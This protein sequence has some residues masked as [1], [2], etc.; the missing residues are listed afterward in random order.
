MYIPLS[1]VGVVASIPVNSIVD[2]GFKLS[3]I[4]S[5]VTVILLGKPTV[6]DISPDIACAA[7]VISTSSAVPSKVTVLVASAITVFPASAVVLEVPIPSRVVSPARAVAAV[8]PNP[9]KETL[10]VLSVIAD[11]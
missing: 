4:T 6:K 8:V 10:A 7:P 1:N 3:A 9:G 2:A 5:L 11:A